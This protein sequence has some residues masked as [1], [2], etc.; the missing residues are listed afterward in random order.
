MH[1]CGFIANLRASILYETKRCFVAVILKIYLLSMNLVP[2]GVLFLGVCVCYVD[3]YVLLCYMD[4]I[5]IK[6][7]IFRGRFFVSFLTQSVF[8]S[9]LVQGVPSNLTKYYG[10]I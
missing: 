10:F 8:Y 4:A 6:K 1:F 7:R 3:C 5:E 2:A 9:N